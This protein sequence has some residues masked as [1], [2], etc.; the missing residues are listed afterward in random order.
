MAKNDAIL[1]DGILAERSSMEALD[2][3]EMF[4]L[5]AFE[6]ILK[7]Y[8]LD[9]AEIDSGWVD[10]KDDGGID[11][12]YTFVNGA[13]VLD[14][15]NFVWPRK[16]V[17]I[18]VVIINCKYRDSFQQEPLNTIFPT[19]VEM[20]DFSKT[21]EDFQG[22]YSEAVIHA[23]QKT[24]QAFR[25]T[26]SALP[27]LSF[28]V[29][30]ASRG[31]EVAQNIKARGH[32]LKRIVADYFSDADVSLEFLGAS[33]L[34]TLHRKNRSVLSLPY[35]EQLSGEN[36]AFVMLVRLD[37]YVNFLNDERG[38]L[39]RYLFDSNIR[40]FL[41]EN[42]VNQDILSSLEDSG[43]PDFWWLNNGIT[44]LATSAIHL[45]KT[46]DGNALQ[47]H[48]V[49]IVNGL[50]TTQT[51]HNHFSA[52]NKNLSDNR[53]VLIK[54]IVSDDSE[55]RDKIIRATNNQ[56]SVELASLTATDKIQRDIEDVLEQHSWFYE[57]RRNYY[58]NIGK[59]VER[60]VHP[61]YLAVSVVALIR[62]APQLSGRLK[63]RF[64]RNSMSYEAV[65][66]DR[67]PI[68]IWPKL[69][70]VMKI[71]D[72][73][74]GGKLPDR[75]TKPRIVA[76]W[77]GATALCTIAEIFKTFEYSIEDFLA[78]NAAII[79]ESRVSE[80]FAFFMA[81]T[82]H[83]YS[84]ITANGRPRSELIC[85]RFARNNGIDGIQVI[86]KWI[87]PSS[88]STHRP[89]VSKKKSTLSGVKTERFSLTLEDIE[90]IREA[91]PAQPWKP[92]MQQ[93]VT[94]KLGL[95]LKI[96]RKGIKLLI[97]QGR[98]FD[99]VN[100][101]VFDGEGTIV[102]VDEERA[103]PRFSI[104]GVFDAACERN[105]GKGYVAGPLK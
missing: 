75:K 23:R 99:Q 56:T 61:L 6:Q 43:A 78:L 60:F 41:G 32:Q 46:Q 35:A 83:P 57:R 8:D 77:R 71:V 38:N 2:K 5:F 34:I 12:F 93:E 98:F 48:D 62:K 47:L 69:V 100:G 87:L 51:I 44:I 11:G 33:E 24:V 26:A 49:Q 18:D 81:E 4:E 14:A 15:S 70:E 37:A 1:L 89:G 10:G 72:R 90:K 105:N 76:A 22:I 88:P 53:C 96:V 65:F 68:L 82:D 27:K 79:S 84:S 3:G 25:C 19:L 45:G 97:E 85:E 55:I 40:D 30:C 54:V 63:T 80:I 74:I 28:R 17:T 16:G 52:G 102:A 86:G 39:R 42:G 94:A 103:D 36:G 31:D 58:K 29:I 7:S 21:P 9:R 92:G 13:L 50:Q 59:P 20:L 64:M 73:G 95:P 67:L 91:L 66:S 104:G 101:V